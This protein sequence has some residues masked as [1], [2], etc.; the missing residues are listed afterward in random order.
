MNLSYRIALAKIQCEDRLESY[1]KLI[2]HFKNHPTDLETDERCYDIIMTSMAK[3]YGEDEMYY[4]W[5]IEHIIH[6]IN[7]NKF[8]FNDTKVLKETIESI[9]N[10][11]YMNKQEVLKNINFGR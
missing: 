9:E 5:I 10:Y 11:L 7:H 1:S 2:E 3:D 6:I 8:L 4:K